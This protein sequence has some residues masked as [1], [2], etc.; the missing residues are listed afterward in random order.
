MTHSFNHFGI[1][2]S[3]A[4]GTA[5]ALAL[6]RAGRQVTLWAHN[7]DTA[8]V[9]LQ[10]GENGRYL[11]GVLVPDSIRI[12]ANLSDVATCQALILVSPTQH[13]RGLVVAMRDIGILENKPLIIAAKGIEQTTS[14][15]LT[16][17]VAAEAP[18][19]PPAILS[20]PSFAHEV[21]MGLPTAL[22]LAMQ[23][24][25]MGDALTHAMASPAF[26]LYLTGDVIGAQIG[27]A[28]KNVM[29]VAC[30]IVTGKAMGDNAR[31]ALITRGLAEMMRLGTAMGGKPE[32]LMGLSG[33]GDLVL[34]CSSPQSRNMSLGMQLGQGRALADIL[35]ERSSVSEGVY[36]A[37]AAMG[38]AARLGVDMPI[39]AAVHA[40]LHQGTD[41]DAT[42][43]SLLA[44]PLKSER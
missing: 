29:A 3:G 9:I 12:T 39:T 1:I 38:M 8:A 14:M 17:V 24:A 40:V 2:G 37:A 35:A 25:A 15:M 32:T 16:D 26:R 7:P 33:L 43:K 22:T 30:G 34:T 5:L 19:N 11:P 28:I 6:H 4:W 13:V 31:A 23:D 36:T 18:H 10:S 41:I 21:A 20:G 27:G 42:I 44:R